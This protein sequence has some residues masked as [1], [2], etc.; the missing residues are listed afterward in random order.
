MDSEGKKG[1]DPADG[2]N[3]Q[4][5]TGDSNK[6]VNLD[7][8]YATRDVTGIDLVVF[9]GKILKSTT[10][11]KSNSPEGRF[12]E[13]ICA[14]FE[15]SKYNVLLEYFKANKISPNVLLKYYENREASF[16]KYFCN[17]DE[18]FQ[19]VGRQVNWLCKRLIASIINQARLVQNKNQINK[20]LEQSKV[21]INENFDE[22]LNEDNLEAQEQIIEKAIIEEH[23]NG[24]INTLDKSQFM[25]N[26]NEFFTSLKTQYSSFG[27][28][29]ESMSRMCDQM[30][31][32]PTMGAEQI[33]QNG[34]KL[35]Q[36]HSQS[37]LQM[38]QLVLGAFKQVNF[39]NCINCIQ[40]N[41]I[42]SLNKQLSELNGNTKDLE[43]KAAVATARVD[44]LKETIK[45]KDETVEAQKQSIE[46]QKQSIAEQKAEIERLRQENEKNRQEN[47]KNRQ[48]NI[49][50]QQKLDKRESDLI[51]KKRQLKALQ[52]LLEKQKKENEEQQ[53]EIKEQNEILKIQ[54]TA[55]RAADNE[56]KKMRINRNKQ[57]Q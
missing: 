10:L 42:V 28:R 7:C 23:I 24:F 57:N 14:G 6:P 12:I 48:E 2:D 36:S 29:C 37:L 22:R 5:N 32:N 18:L 13:F 27:I 53:A 19:F 46:M 44:E 38:S 50:Q 15:D 54:E 3:G 35:I 43:A 4:D 56:F 25:V 47:E 55:I 34:V 49:Q 1:I 8:D 51:E 21:N 31:V 11:C 40:Q 39:A 30:I 16:K 41:Q 20:A 9:G 17:K 45:A 33:M 52:E 26:R